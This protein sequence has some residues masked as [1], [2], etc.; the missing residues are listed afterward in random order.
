MASNVMEI[1]LEACDAR[2]L[3]PAWPT[4]RSCLFLPAIFSLRLRTT[5]AVLSAIIVNPALSRSPLPILL[6]TLHGLLFALLR[7]S[8]NFSSV[9][10]QSLVLMRGRTSDQAG[11]RL[12]PA[13]VQNLVQGSELSHVT[14]KS[15]TSSWI[16]SCAKCLEFW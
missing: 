15:C 11:L 13:G 16:S 10:H 3:N 2:L 5:S 14:G 4:K 7:L 8:M 12:M 9:C 1:V 6:F